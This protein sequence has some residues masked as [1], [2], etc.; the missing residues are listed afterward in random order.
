MKKNCFL[1]NGNRNS[2]VLHIIY[3]TVSQT[4]N[5][6]DFISQGLHFQKKMN[7]IF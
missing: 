7:M 3:M 2:G 6:S 4:D 1:D 5:I